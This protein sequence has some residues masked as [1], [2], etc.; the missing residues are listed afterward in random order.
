MAGLAH[1]EDVRL[2]CRRSL[3][4]VGSQSFALRQP[5]VGAGRGAWE[6]QYSQASMRA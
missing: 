3:A 6:C 4:K 2:R 5:P 1:I